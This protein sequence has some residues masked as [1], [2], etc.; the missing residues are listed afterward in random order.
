MRRPSILLTLI[1]LLPWGCASLDPQPF[2]SFEQGAEKL[3]QSLTGVEAL[4]V[5]ETKQRELGQV[6]ADPAASTAPRHA[7]REVTSATWVVMVSP[8]SDASLVVSSSPIG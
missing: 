2:Q 7:S 8:W 4:V 6:T 5:D 3:S 1:L